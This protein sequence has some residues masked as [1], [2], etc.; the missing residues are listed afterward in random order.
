[1]SRGRTRP[2]AIF[3]VAPSAATLPASYAATLQ[4]IKS[5]LRSARI[6]AVLAANPIVIEAYWQTGKI[7]LA[8][9]QEAAWGAKVIDRLAAD[10][11]DAF[12]D[13]SGL[14]S[15]NLLSMKVFAQAFP[16]SPI[17]KQPVSQLPWGHIIRLIQMVKDPATRDFYIRET[18]VQGWSRSFSKTHFS[19][20]S[21]APLAHDAKPRSRWW[22]TSRSS[23]WSSGLGSPLSADRSDLTGIERIEAAFANQIEPV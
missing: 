14:S 21:L 10:L 2:E 7:I 20:I 6:R 11:Q 22:T 3:P 18:I 5:H 4:E 19:S 1:M 23:C 15:R 8:R 9:Q 13:M 12:P 17:A 16:N